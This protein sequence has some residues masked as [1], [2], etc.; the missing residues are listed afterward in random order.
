MA[1][2]HKTLIVCHKFLVYSDLR[3]IASWTYILN[4]F[5]LKSWFYLNGYT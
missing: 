3:K 5:F 4:W 1:H 2:R